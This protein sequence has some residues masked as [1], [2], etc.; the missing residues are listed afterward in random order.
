VRI[1]GGPAPHL[2]IEAEVG[3]FFLLVVAVRVRVDTKGSELIAGRQRCPKVHPARQLGPVRQAS[4]RRPASHTHH[5][6]GAAHTRTHTHTHT[7]ASIYTRTV[8]GTKRC[9]T[10]GVADAG[11]GGGT[12]TVPETRTDPANAL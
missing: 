1:G 4:P 2:H 12:A 3:K 10:Y 6:S 7:H 8:E 5:M 11:G 9:C